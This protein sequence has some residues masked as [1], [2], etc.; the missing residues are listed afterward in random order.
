[1][2]KPGLTLDSRANE[3][4]SRLPIN[5]TTRPKATCTATNGRITPART[6]NVLPPVLSAAIGATF[7]ARRAG[8]MPKSAVATRVSPPAKVRSRQSSRRSSCTG[9]VR[10]RRACRQ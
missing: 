9:I 4:T 3:S 8:T 5:S 10:P 1:M 7:E 2:A 6:R